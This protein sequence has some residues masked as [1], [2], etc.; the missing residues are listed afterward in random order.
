VGV[1]RDCLFIVDTFILYSYFVWNLARIKSKNK[2]TRSNVCFFLF[3]EQDE[4][5]GL[6]FR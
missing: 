5:H 1:W 6:L 3:E 2:K 4:R